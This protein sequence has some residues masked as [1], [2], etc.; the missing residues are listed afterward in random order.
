MLVLNISKNC[1]TGYRI[2]TR[3]ASFDFVLF[4]EF[5]ISSFAIV[6]CGQPARGENAKGGGPAASACVMGEG[7]GIRLKE[8]RK[9][10]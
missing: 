10:K 9:E 6:Y 5:W 3:S 7:E 2:R 4:S 8:D 1:F